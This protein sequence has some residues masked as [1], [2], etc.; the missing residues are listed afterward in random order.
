MP[1]TPD[2]NLLLTE[3]ESIS[4]TTQPVNYLSPIGFRLDLDYKKFPNAEFSV[5]LASIPDMSATGANYATPQRNIL[6]ESDKVEYS[7]FECTFL[8]DEYLINYREIHDWILS[9]VIQQGEKVTRDLTLNILSS[10]NNVAQKIKFV[11]AYPISLSSIPF[12]SS[13]GD[14]EYLTAMVQFNYSYYKFI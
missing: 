9:Q 2:Y 5:Q 13:S 12:D 1:Y 14:M 8:V 11:D 3:P 6:I 4:I 10:H 7:T